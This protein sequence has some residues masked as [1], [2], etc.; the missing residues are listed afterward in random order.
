M[1]RGFYTAA[2]G[3]IAQQRQQEA[4]SNNIANANTPGYKADQATLRAFPEL[5]M[6]QVGKTKV[7]TAKELQV[8]VQNR[9]RPHNTGLYGPELIQNNQ[10]G[11]LR[12]IDMTTDLAIINGSL[13]DETGSLFFTVQDENGEVRYTRNGNFTVDSQGLLVTNEGYYI[14]DTDGNSIQTDGMEFTVTGDGVLQVEDG[15]IIPLGIAYAEDVSTLVKE[16]NGL[17]TGEAGEVPAGATYS[18]QQGA[19]E[20][21]NVDAL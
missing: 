12:E 8:R 14:L 11:A 21:S 3:I 10:Q 7:P 2:S 9:L 15:P 1:L 5:L 6:Q 4:L 18:V 13:P 17:F 19:L 20:S 16:G